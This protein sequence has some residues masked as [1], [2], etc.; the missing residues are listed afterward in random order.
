MYTCNIFA[1][2]CPLPERVLCV[3]PLLGPEAELIQLAE[4]TAQ[5]AELTA[6]AA[7][8]VT[9]ASFPVFSRVVKKSGITTLVWER[10]RAKFFVCLSVFMW[11]FKL[12]SPIDATLRDMAQT[13]HLAFLL[14]MSRK[15][16][17]L[18]LSS[19]NQL[20]WNEHFP[21]ILP[22]LGSKLTG[23]MVTEKCCTCAMTKLDTITRELSPCTILS[24]ST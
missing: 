15:I 22:Q 5:A 6:Q 9:S 14:S 16:Q 4:L 12:D 23:K 3:N 19:F 18:N 10:W 8:L 13:P 7:E 1:T 20:S 24:S 11:T 17:S 2:V 21:G